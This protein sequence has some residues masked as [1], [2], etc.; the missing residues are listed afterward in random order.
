MNYDKRTIRTWSLIGSTGVFGVA[1]EALKKEY[2]NINVITADLCQF[3]GLERYRK[4]YPEDYYNVGIAEQN[5]IGVAA[6][7]A[8]ENMCVFASTYA[9]FAATR[10]LDQVKI[11]MGYMQLP[12][13]LIG[14][15]AG[16]SS[17]ILGATHMALEDI[18]IM[19]SIPNITILSPADCTETVKCLEAAVN[20]PQPVYIRLTGGNRSPVVYPEDY[21][22]KIGVNHV[23]QSGE[24]ICIIATGSMVWTALQVAEMLDKDQISVTVIN[25]HTIK[26]F[27]KKIIDIAKKHSFLVTMEEHSIIGG[28]GDSVASEMVSCNHISLL[29]LGSDDCYLHAAPYGSLLE[30]SGLNKE[31]VYQRIKEEYSERILS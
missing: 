9:A 15:T 13:K 27:E 20:Y 14:L 18:A 16:Y 3:S 1:M 2:E 30:R 29:K 25:M 11:S 19:K 24:D 26:P 6:G 31:K 23:L 17:G 28:I 12:I 8:S 22:Y 10:A 21:D 5:L 7:L 4:Q